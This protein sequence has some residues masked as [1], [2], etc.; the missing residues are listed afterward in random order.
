[1]NSKEKDK[2]IDETYELID[3][4]SLGTIGDLLW[5]EE[6]QTKLSELTAEEFERYYHVVFYMDFALS[7]CQFRPDNIITDSIKKW[8]DTVDAIGEKGQEG[9]LNQNEASIELKD[10]FVELFSFKSSV[11]EAQWYELLNFTIELL[12]YQ[13]FM[14]LATE[15]ANFDKKVYPYKT[16]ALE[17][18]EVAGISQKDVKIR[19]A[20]AERIIDGRSPLSPTPMKYRTDDNPDGND[21]E[22]EAVHTM[23]INKSFLL[24][25]N[26]TDILKTANREFVFRLYME[27]KEYLS[28]TKLTAKFRI[29]DSK[30]M[31]SPEFHLLKEKLEH[32]K[33]SPAIE[34]R[35][36]I[37]I[38]EL[39]KWQTLHLCRLLAGEK[40]LNSVDFEPYIEKE[41]I[42]S[43]YYFLTGE[44]LNEGEAKKTNNYVAW[45][46]ST[47]AW[48]YLMDVLIPK[49]KPNG[50]WEKCRKTIF[51]KE[52]NKFMDVS[53]LRSAK[54]DRLSETGKQY[55]DRLVNETK[56][57][58]KPIN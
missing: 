6:N 5:A 57:I 18:A 49:K 19:L 31:G 50:L 12:V 38:D 48:R 26:I 34:T 25:D 53:T 54:M 7:Y 44:E 21:L 46:K 9:A 39:R 45:E 35:P 2:I 27:M 1:M 36:H 14:F 37:K 16:I 55:L 40:R 15:R 10:T 11:A 4:Q 8:K 29:I 22:V 24:D 13:H 30:I 56:K 43:L 28:K 23:Y 47:D 32:D 52:Q 58:K 33:E 17:E 51:F 41:S 3:W 20:L 42:A